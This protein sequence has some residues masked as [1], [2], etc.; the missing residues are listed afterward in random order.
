MIFA[1]ANF[2]PSGQVYAIA[3]NIAVLRIQRRSR[4]E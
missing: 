2:G 3:I 4:I 1:D